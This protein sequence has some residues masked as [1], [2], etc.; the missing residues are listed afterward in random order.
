MSNSKWSEDI[1]SDPHVKEASADGAFLICRPRD[2]AGHK[3]AVVKARLKRR[4]DAGRW[5]DHKKTEYHQRNVAAS[6]STKKQVGI[7]GFF[8]P[9]RVARKLWL[10]SPNL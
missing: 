7:T 8:S 6:E 3:G 4:Y 1:L 10:R 5:S 2:A 9:E